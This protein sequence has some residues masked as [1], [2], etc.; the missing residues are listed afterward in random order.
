MKVTVSYVHDVE[1]NHGWMELHPV[2]VIEP[3][4]E[5]FQDRRLRRRRGHRPRARWAL[6]ST[7][8]AWPGR[9]SV[10]RFAGRWP[11]S[12]RIRTVG[13]SQRCGAWSFEQCRR[14]HFC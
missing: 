13:R 9:R 10:P 8:A 1:A 7:A 11:W 4:N 5:D 3:A 14:R 6:R 2:T 12:T